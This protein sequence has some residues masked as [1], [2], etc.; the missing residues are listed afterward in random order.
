[1]KIRTNGARDLHGTQLAL[2]GSM[3]PLQ[4][5]VVVGKSAA[6]GF[7]A[8]LADLAT[9]GIL[10]HVVAVSPRIASIPALLLGV[11]VQFVG[12]K[13]VAFRDGSDDWV[14]QG[15]LF[16]GAEAI[17]FAANLALFDVAVRVV[18]IPLLVLRLITSSMV[19]FAISLP[20]WSRIF[21]ARSEAT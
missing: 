3:Q 5:A 12:N 4:P 8:T 14:R 7:L 17:S 19:Y 9:L 10:T 20:L 6:V 15:V 21:A 2:L 16:L 18:P 11:L 13:Y 1:M